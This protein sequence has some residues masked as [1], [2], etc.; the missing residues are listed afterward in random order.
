VK[1]RER[2]RGNYVVVVFVFMMPGQCEQLEL[3]LEVFGFE[4]EYT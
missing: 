2:R 3:G 1:K 4:A